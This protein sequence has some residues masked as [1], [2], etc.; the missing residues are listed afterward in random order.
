VEVILTNDSAEL[1]EIIE[2]RVSTQT[3]SIEKRPTN[4]FTIA[5]ASIA[6]LGILS[7]IRKT[8]KRKV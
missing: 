7:G 3:I 5:G 1:Q 8:W 6:A 4:L 2:D